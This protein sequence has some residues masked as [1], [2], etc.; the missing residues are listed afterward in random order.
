MTEHVNKVC[1]GTAYKNCTND[2][3]YIRHTQFAGS[4]PLCEDCAKTDRMFL[5][6]DTYTMWEVISGY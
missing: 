2:A 3:K 1:S 5:V 6:E 4:H